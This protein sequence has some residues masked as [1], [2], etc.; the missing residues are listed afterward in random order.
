MALWFE[1]WVKAIARWGRRTGIDALPRLRASWL[2]RWSGLWQR[3]AWQSV[4]DAGERSL[5]RWAFAVTL[6]LLLGMASV[7]LLLLDAVSVL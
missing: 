3:R 5:R 4:F 6:F 7:V 1:R 2:A